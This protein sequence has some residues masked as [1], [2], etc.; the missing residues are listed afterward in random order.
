W[1]HDRVEQNELKSPVRVVSEAIRAVESLLPSGLHWWTQMYV[2]NPEWFAGGVAVLAALMWLGAS[3]DRTIASRMR[4]IWK[5]NGS[6]QLLLQSAFYQRLAAVRLSRPYKETFRIMKR[7]V[8]PALTAVV[9]VWFVVGWL[10][11]LIM[12]VADSAGLFCAEN[13]AGR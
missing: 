9:L 8:L 3:I 2:A 10:N 6:P 12:N 4:G 13:A 7:Y 1:L 5:A 11:H